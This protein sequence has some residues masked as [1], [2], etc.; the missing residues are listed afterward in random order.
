M[1][2]AIYQQGLRIHTPKEQLL[3]RPSIRQ[4]QATSSSRRLVDDDGQADHFQNLSDQTW[5]H[6]Y[7]GPNQQSQQQEA[8]TQEPEDPP[9]NR[10]IN[11]Y[12]SVA[13]N[14][15]RP[16][17][18]LP[19]QQIM[20]YPVV[21]LAANAS[22]NQA[23]QLMQQEQIHYL[24]LLDEQQRLAGILDDRDL[25]KEAAGIGPLSQ[26]ATQQDTPKINLATATAQQLVTKPL[27]TAGLNTDIRDIAK[28][29]LAQ[30]IRALPILDE[31]ENLQGL[32]TRSD[33]MLA[34]ANQAFEVW[35]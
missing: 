28:V 26:Q 4:T 30:K 16:S 33:L 10:A 8:G 14:P 15:T 3:K 17:L 20:R 2:F 35:G 27:V 23:W 22:L 21:T 32:I 7:Q 12:T 19:A 31:Q 24:V 1:V 9:T 5:I 13:H 6:A 25:L 29:M 18:V 34:L 11:A